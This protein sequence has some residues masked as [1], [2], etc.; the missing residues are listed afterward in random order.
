MTDI[1]KRHQKVLFGILLMAEIV[2]MVYMTWQYGAQ[3]LDSDDSAEM[4]L[5]ELLSREG[6][7]MSK[8]W[9]YS[10][11]LRVLNTQLV[12]AP[13]F[14][15]FSD[16]RV[17]RAVG[18]GILLVILLLSFFFL[19]R[20]LKLGKKLILFAPL[21]VWPF[22]REYIQFVL[23][24][25]FYIPHLVI[26]FL[27]LA[28]CLNSSPRL[29]SL[30]NFVLVLL[31]FIAGLGGVRLVAVCYLP[32]V[33]AT[34]TSLFP[35]IRSNNLITKR[36]LFRSLFAATAAVAGFFVN[37]K[38]LV[39]SYS[40]MPMMPG[41]LGLPRWEKLLPIIKSIPKIMGAITPNRSIII[42]FIVLLLCL[43]I[44]LML[45]R[46]FKHWKSLRQETQI[47][48]LYF[49]FSF[50]ITVFAPVIS[51]QGWSNRYMLL[52]GIGFIV[53][54]AAYTDHFKSTG[55]I[56]KILC[57]F[58]LAAELCSG[59]NQYYCFAFMKQLP[60]KNPA[61]SYI[62]NSGLKF[63]F[64]DWDTSD[65]LT[66]LSNGRIHLCKIGNFKHMDAWYWLMEKDFQKYAKGEPVFLILANKR[67]SYHGG[68]PH[69]WGKW[70]KKD[71]TYLESGKIVF[72]DQYY[73]VWKYESYEQFE[74]LVGKKF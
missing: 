54:L 71:L 47:L 8:N 4:I 12:M 35:C 25:L 36:F 65:V 24:G 14:C 13:L 34:L 33:A 67:F 22:S 42:V 66:E 7:I 27:T 52:P 21:I 29:N 11:E 39:Q 30:R 58:I 5:A 15:L 63:G 44:A 51:T 20:S 26:I 6:G 23:Y 69:V 68:V 74:A 9:Y 2:L 50:S 40:F 46:S 38:I 57:I 31:S 64:G 10:T 55:S 19:C 43:V 62:L 18:T 56:R 48:L 61:F 72:Q 53:I 3:W 59:I 49:L 45:L 32:L 28:L 70:E 60:E 37:C 73:T 17:V 1:M 41:R 16:W